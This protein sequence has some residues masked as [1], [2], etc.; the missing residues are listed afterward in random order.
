MSVVRALIVLGVIG[1]GLQLG[2]GTAAAHG[3]GGLGPEAHLPRI[4]AL[5]P[6]DP[7]LDRAAVVLTLG[8]GLGLFLSGFAALRELSPSTPDGSAA[9]SS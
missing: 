8:G 7:A 3:E 9:A 5:D 6:G 1:F 4:V 2:A